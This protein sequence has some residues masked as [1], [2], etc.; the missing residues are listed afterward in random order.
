MRL[1][2]LVGKKF[3][4][5]TVLQRIPN[6]GNHTAYICQCSCG[7]QTSI[8]AAYLKDGTQSCGCLHSEAAS[9][10]L[11]ALLTTH[12]YS[13]TPFYHVW[14]SMKD[15]CLNPNARAYSN[16]GGRGIKV[17]KRWLKFMNFYKDMIDGYHPSLSLDRIDVNGN[18]CKANCR[19][20]TRSEQQR[21]RR[22]YKWKKHE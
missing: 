15:R 20:A 6:I 3:G 12:N 7:K 4:R 16:Y 9:K 19:W 22:P 10:N 21:N 8:K 5:L 13:R 2:N 18:Y 11:A 1:E 17:V 14:G